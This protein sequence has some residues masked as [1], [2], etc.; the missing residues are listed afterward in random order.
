MLY[1]TDVLAV[2]CEIVFFSSPETWM[3]FA[4]LM[5]NDETG[6]HGFQHSICV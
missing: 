2:T 5:V 6:N 3:L 1:L 4:I